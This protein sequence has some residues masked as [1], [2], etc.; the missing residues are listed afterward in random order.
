MIF[1]QGLDF[2]TWFTW[3]LTY[4]LEFHQLSELFRQL[5]S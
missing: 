5:Y 3:F 4:E 1:I 2:R